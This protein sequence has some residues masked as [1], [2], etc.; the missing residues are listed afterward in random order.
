MYICVYMCVR[1]YMCIQVYKC[2]YMCIYVHIYVYICVYMCKKVKTITFFIKIN[3]KSKT[4]TENPCAKMQKT[5][6]SEKNH[7]VL[8]EKL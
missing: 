7:Y 4:F 3:K 1:V 6:K 8:Y 5:Q 2:V